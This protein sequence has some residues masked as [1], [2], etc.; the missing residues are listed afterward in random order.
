MV[1]DR[2]AGDWC[3]S[4]AELP[5]T[6]TCHPSSCQQLWQIIGHCKTCQH[7]PLLLGN[8]HCQS[9]HVLTVSWPPMRNCLRMAQ[10]DDWAHPTGPP[11]TNSAIVRIAPPLLPSPV[12]LC[13]FLVN[14][15]INSIWE[16][17]PLWEIPFWIAIQGSCPQNSSIY[18]FYL[19]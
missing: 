17:Y 4:L 1:I 12:V 14:P 11:P 18:L 8:C 10:K 13:G 2:A 5:V 15:P 9:G 3:L 19:T 7:L 6:S 16:D